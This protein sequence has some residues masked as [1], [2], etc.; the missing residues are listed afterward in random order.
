MTRSQEVFVQ[1]KVPAQVVIYV[2]VLVLAL[3]GVVLYR[4]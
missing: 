3:S 1:V 2:I 4:A